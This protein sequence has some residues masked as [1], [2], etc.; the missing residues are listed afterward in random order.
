VIGRTLTA[1][2]ATWPASVSVFDH[3]IVYVP[4]FDLWLDGTAEFSRLRELPVDDQGVMALTVGADGDATLRRTPASSASDN[5]SRRTISA[6]VEVDGTIR[7][8]GATYVRGEDAP[9]LRRQLEPGESKLGYVRDHLA[10][11]LPAVEVHDVQLP[12][13]LS[14]TVSLSFDGE[15]TSFHGHRS[16]TLPSSWMERNYVTTLAAK[17]SRAQD[18]LLEAPWTTTEEIHIELPSGAHLASVPQNQSISSEFGNAEIEYAT[19][20]DHIT[21]LST[22][23]F[24]ATRIPAA[25]YA[26]FRLFAA[27]VE[28]AFRRNL[29]VELP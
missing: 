13:S 8:S 29:E 17:N 2:F 3:A 16:A 7:F 6:R 18:L 20:G 1:S 11:V 21:V 27:D 22:V 4:E 19:V 14:D 24:S 23:K 15:L 28:T 5:Y 10:Q 26:A 12:L 9:E 25:Q